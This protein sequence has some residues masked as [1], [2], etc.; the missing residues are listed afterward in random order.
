MA[1]T[2]RDVELMRRALEL[3]ARGAGLT[4]P[5]PAVGAV[6]T[7]TGGEVKAEGSHR[8]A[9]EPHAEIEALRDAKANG[10]DP[11]GATMYVTMEP[12][13]HTGK[14][15][16]CTEALIEAGLSRVVIGQRDP[17]KNAGGGVDRLR[18]AGIDVVTGVLASEARQMNPGFNTLHLLGRPLV[19]VKWAMS[20]DGC[21]AVPS[22]DSKWITGP[23]AREEVHR[24][25]ARHDAVVAGIATVLRDDARLTV[26]L[27]EGERDKVLPPDFAP[28][29][30]V[31]DSKLRLSPF[32]AFVRE[33][34]EKALLVCCD[35]AQKNAEERLVKAGAEVVR[36]PSGG[37]GVSLK[38]MLEE[39][40]R[41]DL[42]SVYVEGGRTIAGQ[43]FSEGLVDHV[44]AWIAPR[45]V[46]GGPEHLGPLRRRDPLE[47]LAQA[48]PLHHVATQSNGQDMLMEG[49]VT[50]HLFIET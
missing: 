28:L 29:R 16:P 45:V 18:D 47:K 25:R 24:R 50:D 36:V 11:K 27:P 38:A 10:F 31:T 30:V 23:A 9:G 2:E 33:A 26:R 17:H 7:T 12:C 14:T 1:A 3:A 22:G 46:G 42:Q 13:N 6:M 21:T 37:G 5:N 43:F 39:L 48:T 41:R 40:K 44:E 49:W 34:D 19:T 35:D 4:R 32:S 8:R 20:L 15:G